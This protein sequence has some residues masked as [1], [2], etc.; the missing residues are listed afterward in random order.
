M[1]GRCQSNATNL[2]FW[3]SHGLEFISLGDQ[4]ENSLLYEQKPAFSPLPV[5]ERPASEASRVRGSYVSPQRQQ[6]SSGIRRWRFRLTKKKP[7]LISPQRQQGTTGQGIA[8][9]IQ[10]VGLVI[11]LKLVVPRW[12]FGLTKPIEIYHK[13]LQKIGSRFIPKRV[14]CPVEKM[15]PQLCPLGRGRYECEAR[16]AGEG[17]F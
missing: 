1:S 8:V 16:E 15:C 7:T 12:R 10:A 14:H 5:R 4:T 3:K 6:G 17:W 9:Q 13:L 11:S 2:S